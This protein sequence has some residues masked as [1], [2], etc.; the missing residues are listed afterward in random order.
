MVHVIVGKGRVRNVH[1]RRLRDA[2]G[3]KL[4]TL[5]RS[6]I[7][8]QRQTGHQHGPFDVRD[9]DLRPRRRSKER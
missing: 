5:R 4:D 7:E 3:E 2:R 8:T 1:D 6:Q 9:Y